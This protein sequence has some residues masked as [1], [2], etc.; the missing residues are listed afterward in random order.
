MYDKCALRTWSR[1]YTS[2]DFGDELLSVLFLNS[3]A[4]H[5]LYELLPRSKFTDLLL[6]DVEEQN[7]QYRQYKMSERSQLNLGGIVGGN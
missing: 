5:W 3:R 6:G 2:Q 7:T 4:S 1:G